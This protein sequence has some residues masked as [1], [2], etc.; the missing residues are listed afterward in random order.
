MHLKFVDEYTKWINGDENLT[1]VFKNSTVNTSLDFCKLFKYINP[2]PE[3]SIKTFQNWATETKN[4]KIYKPVKCGGPPKEKVTTTKET[5]ECLFTTLM[6]FPFWTSTERALYMNSDRGSNA[7]KK[8]M[9]ADNVR[10]LTSKYGFSFKSACFS[11]PMRNILGFTALRIV[12]AKTMLEIYEQK[13]TMFIFAD[14]C[15]INFKA[16][17]KKAYGYIGIS[18][19]VNQPL[20]YDTFNVLLVVVPG[21]GVIYK[22]SREKTNQHTYSDFIE[23]AVRIIRTYICDGDK[24]IALVQD[25][26]KYHN[27]K[28]VYQTLDRIK[29]DTFPIVPY[30]PQLNEPAEACFGYCKNNIESY[31]PEA[32][33][34]IKTKQVFTIMQE[35]W[36]NVISKFNA[37]MTTKYFAVWIEILKHVAAGNPLHGN[38]TK[39][40]LSVPKLTA[41]LRNVITKRKIISF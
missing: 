41:Q 21:F 17:S 4:M 12:W 20:R 30:S 29:V 19:L 32:R 39:V 26:A 14:E 3:V 28:K 37:E 2:S 10:K 31:V 33:S 25:N 6:D 7:V 23:I 18:P 9:T 22:M 24:Q 38:R 1:D 40:K 13:K 34:A 35:K 11:P 16:L 15:S 8:N 36:E 5:V 27:T